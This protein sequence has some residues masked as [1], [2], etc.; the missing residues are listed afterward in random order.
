MNHGLLLPILLP[1]FAGGVLAIMPARRPLRRRALSVAAA[2]ALVPLAAWLLGEARSGA[3]QVYAIGNWAAPF[4][5]V[6]QLDRLSA[7]ML[8]LTAVLGAVCACCAGRG[9]DRLGRHFDA[10]FQFQL[11]GLN[12]AFLA[13]DIFNLFVFFEIL[14]IA[15]YALLVHGGGEARIRSGLH[16]VVLNLVGSSFFLVAIGILYG[17]TGTLNMAHMGE[18]LAR[19]DAEAVPLAAAA[20]AM[21]ML[22]FGLKAGLF[23]LSFWL[24][25]AYA[26]AAGSVA[27]LFAIMTKVGVY[28]IM[29]CHALMFDAGHGML[30][31]F[32]S[33]WLWWLALATMVIGACGALAAR[34]MKLLTAYLV[35]VSVGL[36]L[37]SVALQSPGAWGGALYYLGSTTLCTAGLFLLADALEG[38]PT[39]RTPEP[40]PRVRA[41]ARRKPITWIAGA[42]FL[43]GAIGAVGLPPLSGFLGKAMVLRA[44]PFDAQW[45]GASVLWP[46]ILLTGLAS[47]VAVSRT[48]TRLVW[49]APSA[50]AGTPARQ[51]AGIVRHRAAP[52][53]GK[54]ACCAALLA[55]SI[56]MVVFAQPISRYVDATALQLLDRPAYLRAVLP[57]GEG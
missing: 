49:Q 51:V 17:L 5:I 22:V 37:A 44:A 2:I 28:A 40:T 23:P 43:T 16:Y 25:R 29:R 20:G 8:L 53:P 24:P 41:V 21:L 55:C 12:G 30:A 39:R 46:A 36:L 31:T 27:G 42:L 6:L 7:L 15:S 35:L 13:G 9:D 32:A 33:R 14:L 45:H 4:G 1:M 52:D 19:L 10:L 48:G 26:S 54:L 38:L 18:R 34:S 47:L 50:P 56:G 57:N 11:M 3:I